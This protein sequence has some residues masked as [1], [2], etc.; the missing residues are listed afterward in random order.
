MTKSY[1][2]KKPKN[3]K[4]PKKRKTPKKLHYRGE[5]HDVIREDRS[6]GFYVLRSKT[7]PG[8]EIVVPF[9]DYLPSSD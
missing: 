5:L 6:K 4:K 2:I 7:T 9:S 1:G 3:S 8:E